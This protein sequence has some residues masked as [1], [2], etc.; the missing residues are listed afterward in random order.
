M[1]M[2]NSSEL[3]NALN[4]NISQDHRAAYAQSYNPNYPQSFGVAQNPLH[5]HEYQAQQP[6]LQN[7]YPSADSSAQVQYTQP[8]YLEHQQQDSQSELQDTSTLVQ[9]VYNS[10]TQQHAYNGQQIQQ[11]FPGSQEQQLLSQLQPQAQQEQ[12]C[13]QLHDQQRY[14]D[15]SQTQPQSSADIPEAYSTSTP[16]IHHRY[17]ANFGD[18]QSS[19]FNTT[20]NNSNPSNY[21]TPTTN[22]AAPTTTPIVQNIRTT[23]Q[24]PQ[25]PSPLSAHTTPH[26][27]HHQVS[28]REAIK[29][30]PAAPS[31]LS[32]AVPQNGIVQDAHAPPTVVETPA[33][34]N[35]YL[36]TTHD[37]SNH[38]QT[39]CEF[40]LPTPALEPRQK[41]PA[42]QPLV[43][44]LSQQQTSK[45]PRASQA[46]GPSSTVPPPAVPASQQASAPS[47]QQK[48]QPSRATDR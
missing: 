28:A 38:E 9:T 31:S 26:V 47:Q 43:H 15:A 23:S 42:V 35:P 24:Y 6:Q 20:T 36:P 30:Q 41:T 45:Q 40:M 4:P 16:Q 19:S 33:V 34:A 21:P 37:D 1:S 12:Q 48:Q 7:L 11:A 10:P 27:Q 22:Y 13:Q 39:S 46:N 18:A 14:Y 29:A 3:A 17:A 8:Q 44:Q 25:Y 32:V 2:H 5:R